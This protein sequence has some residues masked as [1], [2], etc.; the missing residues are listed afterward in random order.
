MP[1][2]RRV[3]DPQGGL[4]VDMVEYPH[5][6]GRAGQM[7]VQCL[8]HEVEM[9]KYQP[10]SILDKATTAL[11]IYREVGSNWDMTRERLTE[12]LG[13]KKRMTISR[14]IVVAR[15]LDDEVLMHIKARKNLPQSFITDNK[16]LVGTGPDRRFRLKPEGAIAAFDRIFEKM[17]SGLS[18]T[19]MEFINEY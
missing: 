16:F 10:S 1:N 19:S 7:A 9:N 17:D 12:V 18:P 15:D 3:F 14:W 4:R 5:D 8:A 6:L 11:R 2:L 13:P